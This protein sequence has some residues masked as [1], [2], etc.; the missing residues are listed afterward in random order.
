MFDDTTHL[1][2]R[3]P[4]D[5]VTTR[6]RA[7]LLHGTPR[8]GETLPPERELATELG[9]SRLTLRAALARLESE[10]LVRARQGDGV[11]VLDPKRHAT[12]VMLAHMDLVDEH[13]IAKAFLELRRAVACEALAL[14]TARMSDSAIDAIEALAREQARE[15]DDMRYIERDLE[16]SRAI[17]IGADNFAMLLLLNTVEAVYRAH[18]R[19]GLALTENRALSL[20]GY[21]AVI[22]L[23]RARDPVRSRDM[24]RAALEFADADALE[25]FLAKKKPRR[26]IATKPKKAKKP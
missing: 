14:A 21:E 8:P 20:A 6:L 5:I 12:L 18:P 9:V 10:G 24:L 2:P 16:V 25:R 26:K 15:A 7:S 3:R 1:T 23:L 4:V 22:A 19:L 17:L 13:G 11:R